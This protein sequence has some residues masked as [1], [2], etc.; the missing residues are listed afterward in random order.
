MDMLSMI[1]KQKH[2]TPLR[3]ICEGFVEEDAGA[4][5]WRDC[6]MHMTVLSQGGYRDGVPCEAKDA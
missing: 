6:V 1:E 5:S 2:T 4:G 3:I